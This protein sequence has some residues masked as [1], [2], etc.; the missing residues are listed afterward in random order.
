MQNNL[1]AP[2]SFTD[3]ISSSLIEYKQQDVYWKCKSKPDPIIFYTRYQCLNY[4]IHKI[5]ESCCIENSSLEH[6][7]PYEF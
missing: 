2:S 6:F 4:K 1:N 3:A 7:S 5:N